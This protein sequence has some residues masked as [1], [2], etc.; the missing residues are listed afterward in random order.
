MTQMDVEMI[1]TSTPSTNTA[2]KTE[3]LYK[4]YK[5]LQK[6]LELLEIQE[7]YIKE[8]TKNLQMQ[9]TRAKQEI[10]TIQATP[11]SIGQFNEI[12]DDNYGIIQTS[13]GTTHCARIL[14][15]INREELPLEDQYQFADTVRDESMEVQQLLLFPVFEHQDLLCPY[16]SHLAS[17]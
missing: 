11:L 12:V 17:L 3:D 1:D 14:S 7:N 13:S 8:E 4:K 5:A 9:Y 2:Q 16:M 15:T 6:K 10:K